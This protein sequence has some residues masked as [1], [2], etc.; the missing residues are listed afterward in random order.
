VGVALSLPLAL[1]TG[2]FISPRP[3]WGAPDKAI[4]LSSVLHALA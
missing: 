3:P 1:A 4:M 2:Q